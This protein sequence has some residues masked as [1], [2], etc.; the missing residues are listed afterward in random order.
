[1]TC[2]AASFTSHL[3]DLPAFLLLADG[4]APFLAHL[5]LQRRPPLR[6]MRDLRLEDL[7]ERW[8]QHHRG[9]PAIGGVKARTGQMH[10]QR[11]RIVVINLYPV[12]DLL[13]AETVDGWPA[14]GYSHTGATRCR[15]RLCPIHRPLPTRRGAQTPPLCGSDT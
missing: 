12:T 1:M 9:L 6:D 15:P 14:H 2:Q 8:R 11:D 3:A 4:L 7:L 13:S 10:Q 5:P